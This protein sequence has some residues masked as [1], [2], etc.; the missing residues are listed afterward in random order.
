MKTKILTS[1]LVLAFMTIA[2]ETIGQESCPFTAASTTE[3]VAPYCGVDTDCN[4]GACALLGAN[5]AIYCDYGYCTYCV[6]TPCNQQV[7]VQ[8]Y[9]G[10]CGEWGE[11]N[12]CIC[13]CQ[14]QAFGPPATSHI[15]SYYTTAQCPQCAPDNY[16]GVKG[17][18]NLASN[19]PRHSSKLM[20]SL[21]KQ[22]G[23]FK[24]YWA[25]VF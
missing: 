23:L 3:A 20:S 9:S 8:Y 21:R 5:V 1:V 12:V 25:A 4:G 24:V 16:A 6:S 10:T 11:Y 13:C 14:G 18:S 2:I 22:F 15:T 7:T 17:Y 19:N